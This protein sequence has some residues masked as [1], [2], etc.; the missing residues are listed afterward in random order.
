MSAWIVEKEH[1]DA[2]VAAALG[3]LHAP[4][5]PGDGWYG[6]RWNDETPQDDWTFE[7]HQTHSR[8]ATREEADRI[9]SMIW[10]ECVRSVAYRYPDLSV[11]ELPDCGNYKYRRPWGSERPPVVA[12]LKAISCYEYQS[13]EHP[14]W[15]TSEAHSFCAALR[16]RMIDELPGYEDANWGPPAECMA[17]QVT[18]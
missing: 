14:E 4:Q 9:G 10:W 11:D 7:D 15:K 3:E 1:I 17:E 13:C 2:L 8:T 16:D 6:P 12:I 18:A 5:Y